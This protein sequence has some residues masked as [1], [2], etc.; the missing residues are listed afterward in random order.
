[1]ATSPQKSPSS[2]KSP[3]PKSPPSRKKDDSF[4]GK[5]GG[6]LARRKK[7]KEGKKKNQGRA[8]PR[9]YLKM[10]GGGGGGSGRGKGSGQREEGADSGRA[11]KG[12]ARLGPR[13]RRRRAEAPGPARPGGE[14]RET[15]AAGLGGCGARSQRASAAPSS[16]RGAERPG[17]SGLAERRGA[18]GSGA[19]PRRGGLQGLRAR[20]LT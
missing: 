6:T 4:L 3:T 17:M 9:S 19:F 18:E 12:G 20:G 5:L 15:P 10:G 2:P 13:L 11:L 14:P 7:A 16:E 1:M 8:R